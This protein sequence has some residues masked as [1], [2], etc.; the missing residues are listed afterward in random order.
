MP[1]RPLS[2]LLFLL[3]SST[4]L[5]AQSTITDKQIIGTSFLISPEGHLLTCSH[6]AMNAKSITVILEGK[7]TQAELLQNNARADIALFKIDQKTPH[8]LPLFTGEIEQGQEVRAFGYPLAKFLGSELKVTRG[9]I[10]GFSTEKGYRLLQTDV[11]VNPGNSGGPLTDHAGAVTGLVFAKMMQDIGQMG[12]GVPA[13]ELKKMLD[14]HKVPYDGVT[15]TPSALTGPELVKKVKP[16]VLPVLDKHVPNEMKVAGGG[17]RRGPAIDHQK[18]M[19]ANADGN[20]DGESNARTYPGKGHPFQHAE[21]RETQP[22]GAILV[23]FAVSTGTLV[24]KNCIIGL[25]PIYRKGGSE[26]YGSSFGNGLVKS[27]VLIA[28]PGYAVGAIKSRLDLT[29]EC[30]Q[31]VYYKIDGD[32]LDEKNKEIS[33]VAGQTRSSPTIT[34]DSNGLLPVGI[35]GFTARDGHLFGLGFVMKPS[36]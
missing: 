9:S 18:K 35:H 17:T 20:L 16:A 11:T 34:I 27:S 32:R 22:D 26:I 15:K 31:L 30:L 5:P 3:I 2:A 23:G 4:L 28:P 13:G 6:V 29:L 33:T 8:Y 21:F 7:A 19:Q 24:G 1:T 10:A 14:R 36:K 25:Q 12:F